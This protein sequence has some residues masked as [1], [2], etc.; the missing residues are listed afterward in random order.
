MTHEKT[1]RE[2]YEHIR[3][4]D[5]KLLKSFPNMSYTKGRRKIAC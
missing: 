4:Q 2:R 5:L 3:R 1:I